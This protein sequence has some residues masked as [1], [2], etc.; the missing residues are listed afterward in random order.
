MISGLERKWVRQL[1]GHSTQMRGH[2]SGFTLVEM[3]VALAIFAIMS[4]CRR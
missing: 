2:Q 4:R 1:R 3:L